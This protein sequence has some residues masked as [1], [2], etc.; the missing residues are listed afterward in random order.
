MS[1]TIFPTMLLHRCLLGFWIHFWIMIIV[2]KP[3]NGKWR[4]KNCHALVIYESQK[5]RQMTIDLVIRD[6]DM[7]LLEM[8]RNSMR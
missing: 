2:L 4:I 3:R 7:R 6:K 5:P 1:L 8:S